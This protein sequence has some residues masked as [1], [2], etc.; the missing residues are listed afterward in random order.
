MISY[1]AAYGGRRTVYCSDYSSTKLGINP[2]TDTVL[3]QMT[4]PSE[5][6]RLAPK[7]TD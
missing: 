4:E 6:F 1:I 3:K 2:A 7:L 5:R